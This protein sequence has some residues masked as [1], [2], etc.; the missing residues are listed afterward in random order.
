M[1][2]FFAKVLAKGWKFIFVV[3]IIWLIYFILNFINPDLFSY[4]RIHNNTASSTEVSNKNDSWRYKIYNMFFKSNATSSQVIASSSNQNINSSSSL[5]WGGKAEAWGGSTNSSQNFLEG[6]TFIYP[7]T[8]K[9]PVRGMKINNLLVNEN[10][11]NYLPD[12]ATISGAIYTG[13]L[14]SYY[15]NADIYDLNG[16]ALFSI[17][18]TSSHDLNTESFAN[19]YGQYNK[20]FNATNYKGEAYMVI[21]PNNGNISAFVLVKIEL[22]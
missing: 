18:I 4:L 9:A 7:N 22:R 15:F 17:P 2:N 16:N 12:G 19:F 20:S 6:K 21:S 5:V 8:S 1:K 3:I 14:D 13:F 11:F 10:N